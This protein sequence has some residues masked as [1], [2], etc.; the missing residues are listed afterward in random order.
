MNLLAYI[1]RLWVRPLGSLCLALAVWGLAIWLAVF[2]GDGGM[3][4]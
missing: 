1:A 4:G 3:A 2:L